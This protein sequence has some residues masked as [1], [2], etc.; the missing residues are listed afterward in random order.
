MNAARIARIAEAVR[1][2]QPTYAERDEPFW[3]AAVAIVLR[4]AGGQ[5]PEVLFIL[6]AVHE[7]DPWSGQVALPGG[8]RDEGENDLADTVVRETREETGIDLRTHGELFGPLDEF[9]PR[10]PV[11]PP[12]IVRP[13]V[14]RIDGDCAI[15]ASNEVSGHFWAPLDALFDPANTRST[16]VAARG[17]TMWRDAIHYEGHVIW[18]MTEIII[19]KLAQVA[20]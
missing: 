5:S 19:H 4:D 2:R 6:R 7:R 17:F 14:A 9:R 16:R 15:V 8:R 20:K 18:G 10:T 12:V 1:A 13:Y 11:L 3:E